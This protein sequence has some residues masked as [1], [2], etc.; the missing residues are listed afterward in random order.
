MSKILLDKDAYIYN[1]NAVANKIGGMDKIYLIAKD[2]SY[3]HGSK[4]C[5]KVA[6]EVGIK[7]AVVKS[8]L[9]ADEISEFFDEILILSHI[10]NGMEN[11]DYVYAI[12]D[13]DNFYSLKSGAKVHIAIDTLMHRNGIKKDEIELAFKLAKEHNIL[14]EG[15]YTHFRSSDEI[16]GDFFVQKQKFEEVKTLARKLSQ[17]F[18]IKNLKF[19]S[20][21]S[22]AIERSE[23]LND[24][25]VR[26]GIAQFG[27]A[28]FD[29]SLNLKKVLSLWANR[30]SKRVLKKGQ[31]IG[32]G[33]VYEAEQDMQI[34][35]YDLGYGDGLFRYNG[36]GTLKL[37]NGCEILGKM[38]M[39]SFSCK[40]LGDEICVFDDANVWAQFFNTISYEI[41]VKL[42]DKINRS[43]K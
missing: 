28:Q 1:L 20:Q 26:L 27:Y 13:L 11:L 10:P 8:I 3:G 38:S 14:I 6:S 15:F 33:G 4:L 39:D 24:D 31:R 17:E 41:L 32:Y 35:T 23:G 43:W 30:V 37:A 19:H 21:N 36:I 18:G 22:A 25:F 16:S 29:D 34:A 7:K 12:N 40:D 42:S 9:E 5:A 2:N